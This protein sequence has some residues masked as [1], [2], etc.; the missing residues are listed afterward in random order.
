MSGAL[1]NG[2][3]LKSRIG[4]LISNSKE[5]VIVS[6]Y[7][8]LPAIQWLTSLTIQDRNVSIIGRLSPKDLAS[9]ASDMNA[10]KA[11]LDNGWT[12][13]LLANLHAKIYMFD[14]KKLFVGSA[15]LTANGL[16]LS[17]VGN[18]E[19]VIETDASESDLNFIAHIINSSTDITHEV[20]NVMAG[21]IDKQYYSV[22]DTESNFWPDYIFPDTTSLFVSDFPLAS[23]GKCADEYSSNPSLPFA[24]VERYERNIPSALNVF[25]KSKAFNWLLSELRQAEG[26]QLYFGALTACLHE[27]LA[28]DPAPYRQDVKDLLGNLLAYVEYLKIQSIQISRPRHSQLV[29][30]L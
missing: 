30:L 19:A 29:T 20:L 9:G 18:L 13:K 10:L 22:D 2:D 3:E 21:L 7:I 11:I 26:Q 23:P 14:R 25:K 24:L 16:K 1:I 27:A 28:D 4:E 6:A 17:G 12:L 15:N 5:I 8:T